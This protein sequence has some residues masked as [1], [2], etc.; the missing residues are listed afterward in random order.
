MSRF[1]VTVEIFDFATN[2]SWFN[3]NLIVS[4]THVKILDK[5]MSFQH[6]P[7]VLKQICLT[8]GIVIEKYFHFG[9]FYG[10]M[11]G[12]LNDDLSSSEL[13]NLGNWLIT[14]IEEYYSTKAPLRPLRVMAKHPER[15]G[16]YFCTRC[17]VVPPME[18]QQLVFPFVEKA[19]IEMTTLIANGVYRPTA[20][21]WDSLTFWNT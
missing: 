9:M 14:Q 1:K 19:K 2:K 21:L 6:Y 17:T 7:T 13:E 20:M 11:D 10:N 15:K 3:N 18:L 12:E 5:E 16:G 8:L 4:P